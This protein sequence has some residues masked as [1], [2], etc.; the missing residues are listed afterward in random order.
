MRTCIVVALQAL[1]RAR[2]CGA[3]LAAFAAST[4][5]GSS[6]RLERRTCIAFCES[7]CEEL[8]GNHSRLAYKLMEGTSLSI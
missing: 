8:V 1:K 6:R 2:M 4:H 5:P 3:H 7:R